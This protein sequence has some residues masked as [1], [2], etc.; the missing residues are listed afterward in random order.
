MWQTSNNQLTKTFT[1]PDFVS[2]LA[3]VN[4]VGALAEE[5]N[6][7]PDIALSYGKVVI[8][9]TTHSQK[10]VTDKDHALAQRIDEL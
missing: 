5:A 4:K 1:F 10:K 7:H 2:A 8:S 9:L 3:F 6:H